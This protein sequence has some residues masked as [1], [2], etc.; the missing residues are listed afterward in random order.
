MHE[1]IKIKRV[2][3]NKNSLN[4][5]AININNTFIKQFILL[6]SSKFDYIK[7]KAILRHLLFIM[8]FTYTNSRH[9]FSIRGGT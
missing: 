8:K 2:S 4:F 3:Q 5:K 9:L 1:I 7:I 6:G